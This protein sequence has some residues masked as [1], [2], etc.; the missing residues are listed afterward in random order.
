[1]TKHTMYQSE[2]DGRWCV[3]NLPD[4]HRNGDLLPP[5][6]AT[7]RWFDNEDEAKQELARR[8]DRKE[9]GT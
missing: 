5:P 4:H 8:I 2:T 7:D 3:V 9:D 1:M 6:Q